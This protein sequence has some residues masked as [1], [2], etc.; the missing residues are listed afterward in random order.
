[1]NSDEKG[2]RMRVQ[3]WSQ[4]YDPEPQGVAPITTTVAKG[5]ST[6]G[7]DVT[8]IA[9]HPHYPNPDWGSRIRPYRE[10]RDGIPVLRLPIWPGR[11]SGFQRI[12]QDLSSAAISNLVAPF[13]PPADALIAVSPSL[14]GLSAPMLYSKL[15][16]VPWILWLQDIVT[17]GAATTGEL[18]EHHPALQAARAFEGRAYSSADRIIAISRAFE[19]RLLEQDVPAKKIDLV[20]N[21]MTRSPSSTP[22]AK[23]ARRGVPRV[24]AMGNIGRT[25]GLEAIVDAFQSN[26]E[27]AVLDAEL[28]ITGSGVAAAAVRARIESSRISMPGVVDSETLNRLLAN[29]HLGLVS[30]KAG[31]QEFNLPSKLMN[32]MAFGIPVVAA[33]DAGSETARIVRDS[34]AGWVTDPGRPEEFADRTARALNDPQGLERASKAGIDFAVE[35]FEADNVSRLIREI[36]LRVTRGE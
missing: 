13:L 4:N 5:L 17:D 28:V 3:I 11:D 27:L 35:H 10:R 14:P 22:G 9:A 19:S 32:Y 26:E 6:L 16:R 8:V 29:A 30:H 31:L 7:V 2:S 20:Y 18:S 12:R 15:R 24:L 1:M 33:V 36:L 25:Q 23:R 21:P 34:G